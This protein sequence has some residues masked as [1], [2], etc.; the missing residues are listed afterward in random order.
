MNQY[1]ILLLIL[2]GG[3][4]VMGGTFGVATYFVWRGNKSAYREARIVGQREVANAE[5]RRRASQRTKEM[6]R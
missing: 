2:I 4:T 6:A 5:A 1:Q 3:P